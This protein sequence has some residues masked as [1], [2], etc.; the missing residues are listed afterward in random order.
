MHSILSDST[1]LLQETDEGLGPSCQPTN[2]RYK[3]N[4][5]SFL[6]SI[7]PGRKVKRYEKADTKSNRAMP[8]Q[9]RADTLGLQWAKMSWHCIGTYHRV[10][11]CYKA[12]RD[13]LRESSTLQVAVCRSVSKESC[14]FILTPVMYTTFTPRLKFYSSLH[15]TNISLI[16]QAKHWPLR[17]KDVS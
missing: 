13:T 15:I 12:N 9:G 17:I 5:V 4:K 10:M 14:V 6:P 2:M 8:S 3:L 1:A 7:Q 16:T 11:K